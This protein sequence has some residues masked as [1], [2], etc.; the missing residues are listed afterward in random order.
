MLT[1]EETKRPAPQIRSLQSNVAMDVFLKEIELP[2]AAAD[3]FAWHEREG[4]FARLM[5]P[6]EQARIRRREGT[7]RDGD[8]TELEVKIGPFWVAWVAEHRDYVAGHSFVDVQLKGPFA[9]WEHTHSVL[10]TDQ[11]QRCIWQDRIEYR[12]PGGMF[13]R[14]VAKSNIL[15]KLR[16]MFAYR[17]RRTIDDLT[18][19]SRYKETAKMKIAITGAGGLVGKELTSLLTTHGHEVVPI[20]RRD[21][22]DGEVHWAP[23]KG[24]IDAQALEGVDVVVHLGG[25]GIANS[26]WSAAHKKKIID[27]RVDGTR[28]ISETLAKLDKKPQALICA[29][30]IG[31]YGDRGDDWVDE[32]SSGDDSFLSDVCQQWEAAAQPAEDAGIRVVKM[33]IGVVLSPRGGALQKMLTPFKMCVGGV[34]G[35]GKQYWSWISIDDVAGAIHHAIVNDNVTGP[36]NCVAPHPVTNREF[37]KTLGKVLS[38]PTIFPMPA[39]AARLALGEMADALLLASTRVKPAKLSETGYEFRHSNLEDALRHV[40]GK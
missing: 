28:L 13:G 15:N 30:A 22:Q 26:R 37:T 6:W 35:S 11:Q 20:V 34:V 8:I 16:A 12:V 38:R 5:P 10:R 19:L 14:L 21:A 18:L 31:M 7:I 9:H 25:E 36:V 4:A 1:D 23:S 3:A 40:L 24:E 27:S 39:F 29:S 32:D 33:R 17:H 2:I